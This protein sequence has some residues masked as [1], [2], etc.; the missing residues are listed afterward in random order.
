M[1][2]LITEEDPANRLAR[3]IISDIKLYN[4][5][6]V[7]QGIENDNLF[8]VL[9]NELK[10]GEEHYNKRVALELRNCTNFFNRAIVDVLIKSMAHIPSKMW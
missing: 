8:E 5:A 3:T 2:I 9:S 1:A 10:E 6:K 7:R 4:E